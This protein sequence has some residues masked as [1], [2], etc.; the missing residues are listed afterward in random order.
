[1]VFVNLENSEL[2]KN[3]LPP[4]AK[5]QGISKKEAWEIMEKDF[6]DS[7]EIQDPKIRHQVNL[8]WGEYKSQFPNLGLGSLNK[9]SSP[10]KLP[11]PTYEQLCYLAMATEK[12]KTEFYIKK[13][14]EKVKMM[15]KAAPKPKFPFWQ[16]IYSFFTKILDKVVQKFGI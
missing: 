1:M 13:E 6:Q 7:I 16:R 5:Q 15:K 9:V 12:F 4:L 2:I 11:K 10:S 14:L 8:W 3:A